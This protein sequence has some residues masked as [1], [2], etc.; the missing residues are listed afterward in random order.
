MKKVYYYLAASIFITLF[1]VSC[2]S[3][4]LDTISPQT[5]QKV[6]ST[7][8]NGVTLNEPAK[9]D[10][11][12]YAH[13]GKYI[14]ISVS[15]QGLNGH[16]HH[17]KDILNFDKDGDGF[18]VKNECNINFRDDGKWD[19]DD[20]DPNVTD[21]R[22]KCDFSSNIV[23]HY[24]DSNFEFDFT[25]T[26]QGDI[27]V[28]SG[29]GTGGGFGQFDFNFTINSIDDNGEFVSSFVVDKQTIKFNGTLNCDNST[30][31]LNIF[32]KT[33]EVNIYYAR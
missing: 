4:L 21:G 15:Q 3:S 14:R 18:P 26:K 9:V 23:G 1:L 17:E 16:R 33:V 8:D 7:K 22:K 19:L 29:Y 27:F 11:C 28:G 31:I 5:I 10:I 2:D 32:D 12:H 24:V 6:P 13:S 20:T 25:I 30:M